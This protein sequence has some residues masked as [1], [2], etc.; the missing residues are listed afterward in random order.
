MS[1]KFKDVCR[2]Y[3][4]NMNSILPRLLK[5]LKDRKISKS[6]LCRD[7]EIPSNTFK[8]QTTTEKP[9]MMCLVKMLLILDYLD[10]TLEDFMKIDIK[11]N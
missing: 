11:E 8:M 10:M 1:T 3:Y 5:V 2:V 6:K 9:N 4:M 7:L